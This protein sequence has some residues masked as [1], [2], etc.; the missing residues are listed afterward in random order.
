MELYNHAH[1]STKKEN[2]AH[3][4]EYRLAVDELRGQLNQALQSKERPAS[5]K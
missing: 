5:V 4:P 3:R 2:L 1:D